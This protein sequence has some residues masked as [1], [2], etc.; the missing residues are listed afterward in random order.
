MAIKTD[1]SGVSAVVDTNI[2]GAD[3][4]TVG[5]SR[6]ATISNVSFRVGY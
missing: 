1:D 6:G 5:D 4:D 3:N 2:S